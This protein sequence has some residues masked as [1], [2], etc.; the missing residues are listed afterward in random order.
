MMTQTL[1]ALRHIA[2][3][4]DYAVLEAFRHFRSDLLAACPE[5]ERL[6]SEVP[7]Q[8]RTVD[9][10]DL[11]GLWEKN[12]AYNLPS[13]PAIQAARELLVLAAEDE[14]LAFLVIDAFSNR[15]DDREA[16]GEILAIGFVGAVW[17]CL[18]STEFTFKSRNM[19]IKKRAFSD[20]QIKTLATIARAILVKKR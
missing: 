15:P 10:Q 17:L 7:P 5:R 1:D 14:H 18:L 3:C 16:V 13:G 12:A 2:R 11:P 9:G 20:Q 19:T 4:N 8:L 6:G